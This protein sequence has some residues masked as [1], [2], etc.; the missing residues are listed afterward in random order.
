MK[1]Y[2]SH[3]L[4]THVELTEERE[5][6]IQNKHPDLLPEFRSELILTIASPDQVRISKRMAHAKLFS[7]WFDDIRMGKHVVVVVMCEENR[8][9]VLTAYLSRKRTMG[10]LEWPI[11]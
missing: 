4:N 2:F 11:T 3:Y 10:E 8:N 6:H 9:W 7:K 1:L 5:R